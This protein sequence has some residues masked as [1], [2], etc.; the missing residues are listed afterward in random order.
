MELLRLVLAGKRA[1]QI[2][3]SLGIAEKTVANR[4]TLLRGKLNIANDLELIK[5]AMAAGV[6]IN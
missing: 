4:K 6:A 3:Q 1:D 5:A 2:A